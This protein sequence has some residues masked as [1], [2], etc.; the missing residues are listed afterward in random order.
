[1]LSRT[2]FSGCPRQRVWGTSNTRRGVTITDL[3]K[4]MKAQRRKPPLNVP[5]YR[6]S[7]PVL[8]PCSGCVSCLTF[9]HCLFHEWDLHLSSFHFLQNKG[10]A[11]P[12]LRQQRL[13]PSPEVTMC[14]P[15]WHF[16]LRSWSW[17]CLP[18]LPCPCPADQSQVHECTSSPA[19][20]PLPL[21]PDI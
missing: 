15:L 4:F 1:M 14:V 5:C 7:R 10:Q 8:F 3:L 17:A 6:I 19:S 2:R 12:A 9:G 16:S 20:H 18:A 13:P 21:I 11:P